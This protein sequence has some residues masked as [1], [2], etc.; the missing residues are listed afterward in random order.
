MVVEFVVTPGGEITGDDDKL[1]DEDCGGGS[2][3]GGVRGNMVKARMATGK[4][5]AV[6][7]SLMTGLLSFSFIAT[8]ERLRCPVRCAL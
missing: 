3:P 6:T 8:H 2:D 1:G 5:I 4:S 7:G